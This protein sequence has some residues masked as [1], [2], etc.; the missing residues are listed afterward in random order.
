M[1]NLEAMNP[2][3]S[4]G[5]MQQVIVEM[6]VPQSQGTGFALQMAQGMNVPGFQLD[7]SY[8]P[9]P[10]SPS[11]EQA[12]RLAAANEEVVIVRGTIEASRIPELEAQPHVLGVWRDSK[13]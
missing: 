1:T 4:E 8:D 7:T 9:V 12:A 6:R 11:E 13:V 2:P 5:G 10:M 3:G